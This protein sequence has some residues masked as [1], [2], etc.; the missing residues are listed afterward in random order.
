MKFYELEYLDK[1]GYVEHYGW[2]VKK[3]NAESAAKKFLQHAREIY[4][5]EIE[6]E[7]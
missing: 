1:Y 6:T 5:N 2:F 7:D 3:E 4:I